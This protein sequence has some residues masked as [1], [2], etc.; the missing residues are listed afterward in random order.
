MDGHHFD[1]LARALG[2]IMSRRDLTR[3]LVGG[4]AVGGWPYGPSASLA[5]KKRKRK[6][7]KKQHAQEVEPVPPSL[8]PPVLNAFGCVDIGQACRGNSGLCCSGVCEGAAPT[9]PD[10]PDVSRCVA[11][12]ASTCQVGQVATMCGGTVDVSCTTSGGVTGGCITTTGKGPYCMH[13]AYCHACS[14]DADCQPFCGNTAAC[15]PCSSCAT[16]GGMACA[17]TTSSPCVF[18]SP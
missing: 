2:S 9:G 1:S 12:D 7:R 4:V 13:Q 11:H 6:K 15:I 3:V 8:P 10:Q 5:K 14:R 16:Y 17:V 18:P